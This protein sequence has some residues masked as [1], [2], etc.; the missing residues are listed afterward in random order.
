MFDIGNKHYEFFDMLNQQAKYFHEG[1]KVM[2]DVMKNYS[3]AHSKMDEIREI[4]HQADKVTADTVQRLNQIFITPID[5][6]D[7]F[8][9]SYGLDDGVDNV[10][11]CL[12]RVIMY[13]VGQ[14]KT[15]GPVKLTNL[16]IQATDELVKATALL[17]NIRANQI[18]ILEATNRI[19]R[20]EIE[21][22]TVYRKE[23]TALFKMEKDAIA[24]IKWKDIL[25]CLED[26][27]D[28]TK[29]ISDTLKGVV[30]KYA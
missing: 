16:L 9:L 17:K 5:R 27:L 2:H 22:D 15:D 7:I 19:L 10:H 21:G 11:G 6:E 3:I 30:M 13:E 26:T 29:H 8:A 1:A 18:N 20:Y 24:L 25:Q 23:M 4:E 12:E 28:Q 14:P